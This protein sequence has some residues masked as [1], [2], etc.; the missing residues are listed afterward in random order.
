[1]MKTVKS[2]LSLNKAWKWMTRKKKIKRISWM[3]MGKRKWMKTKWDRVQT[4]NNRFL[5]R[6]S[7]KQLLKVSPVERVK[8]LRSFSSKLFAQLFRMRTKFDS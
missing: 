3:A 5:I 7:Y 2:R 4:I 6:K 1:M 8:T